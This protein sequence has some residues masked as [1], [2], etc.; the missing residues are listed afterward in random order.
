MVRLAVI[1]LGP[2]CVIADGLFVADAADVGADTDS[3]GEN[4]DDEGEKKT[5]KWRTSM[6]ANRSVVGADSF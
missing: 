5:L 1:V 2:V 3:D 6:S 4:G